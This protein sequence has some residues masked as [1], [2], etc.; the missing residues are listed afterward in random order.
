MELPPKPDESDCCNSGCNPC[1]LDV[2]E[3]QLRKYKNKTLNTKES[4][5]KNCMSLTTYA[6]FEL[7]KRVEHT[8]D[9]CLLTFQY[10]DKENIYCNSCEQLHL[11]Y[12]PGQHFLLKGHSYYYKDNQFTRA[13][14]PIPVENNDLLS[15]TIIVRLYEDGNMS[16]FIK[17][18]E[19][20]TLTLWRGPYGDFEISYKFNYILLIAQG[21]GI[22]PIFAVIHDILRNE[23]CETFLKLFFCCR[24]ERDILLRNELYEFSSFWNF[25][26][27]VF[28]S[29][30]CNVKCKYNE[31]IHSNRLDV[32]AIKTYV[33]DKLNKN[34]QILVCGS[35]IFNQDMLEKVLSC[36]VDRERI[37]LF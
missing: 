23:E 14:T 2:Y 8:A 28:L 37:F 32:N 6:T 34:V 29:N 21:T 30:E 20:N 12:K 1:I 24:T 4:T 5:K 27:E 15:F 17:K 35:E 26:Y 3:E 25:S 22:A 13:Y 19:L 10:V 36:D 31:V 18:L 33:E 7:I 16:R 9:T 11:I